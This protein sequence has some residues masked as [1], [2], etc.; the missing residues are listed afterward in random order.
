MPKVELSLKLDSIPLEHSSAKVTFVLRNVGGS[1]ILDGQVSI[2][3]PA[4]WTL[5]DSSTKPVG[6]LGPGASVLLSWQGVAPASKCSLGS[7][8]LRSR[9]LVEVGLPFLVPIARLLGPQIVQK[10][11]EGVAKLFDIIS[12]DGP[13]AI[14]KVGSLIVPFSDRVRDHRSSTLKQLTKGYFVKEHSSSADFLGTVDRI[15]SMLGSL[16]D[17]ARSLI[18]S[19]SNTYSISILTYNAALAVADVLLWTIPL[20]DWTKGMLDNWGVADLLSAI[21]RDT[22]GIPVRP[23]DI[24]LVA[25]LIRNVLYRVTPILQG[26]GQLASLSQYAQVLSTASPLLSSLINFAEKSVRGAIGTLN[27]MVNGLLE[28]STQYVDRLA[29][30]LDSVKERAYSIVTSTIRWIEDKFANPILF[31]FRWIGDTIVGL[32]T[33]FRHGLD[34]VLKNLSLFVSWVRRGLD[35]VRNAFYAWGDFLQSVTRSTDSSWSSLEARL[36]DVAR[37]SILVAKTVLN[38]LDPIC[39][40]ILKYGWLVSCVP[41]YGPMLYSG[42]MAF[43]SIQ[44]IAKTLVTLGES[45]LPIDGIETARATQIVPQ[46]HSD[47]IDEEE[48]RYGIIRTSADVIAERSK[49]LRQNGE[50]LFSIGYCSPTLQN[51]L[52][53]L[54][55]GSNQVKAAYDR[56]DYLT[57]VTTANEIGKLLA[58][59]SDVLRIATPVYTLAS[60]FAGY[61]LEGMRAPDLSV[62]LD[63]FVKACDDVVSSICRKDFEAVDGLNERLSGFEALRKDMDERYRLFREARDLIH[64]LDE[65]IRQLSN[66]R[67]LWIAPDP[68]GLQGARED[69]SE[70][71]ARFDSG[72]YAGA[73]TSVGF[74]FEVVNKVSE[75][76]ATQ[77]RIALL[78]VVAVAMAFGLLTIWAIRHRSGSNKRGSAGTSGDP[79]AFRTKIHFLSGIHQPKKE[80]VWGILSPANVVVRS[81]VLREYSM[82]RTTTN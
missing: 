16:E 11:G 30:W 8:T 73:K 46:I 29:G 26:I 72:D 27:G 79:Q 2:S 13:Y 28:I 60:K 4:G 42:M 17:S 67:F 53:D 19:Q 34:S 55:M 81:A 65:R 36:I 45:L 74:G 39:D 33:W 48:Q 71:I 62:R 57:T 56:K 61:R 69:L 63:R 7:L 70:A 68:R 50:A 51:L 58:V 75:E 64:S 9:N 44:M 3:M 14:Y 80:G 59:V 1:S 40:G 76:Y 47:G 18:A 35:A 54:V 78:Q 15:S 10:V 20:K 21:I 66:D 32:L 37:Q 25:Y 31:L 82:V 52:N 22:F 38:K 23:E 12:E 24:R 77:R 49:Q 6:D 5:Q 43:V 41:E